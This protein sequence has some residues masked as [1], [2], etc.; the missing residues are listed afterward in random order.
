LALS[1]AEQNRLFGVLD[2][3]RFRDTAPVAVYAVLLDEGLYCY[4]VGTIYRLPAPEGQTL[5]APE[6]A[7]S[8]V[9]RAGVA[10]GAPQ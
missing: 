6:T 8:G 7:S 10:R 1:I 4:S 9:Y 5:G 3:E 2:S